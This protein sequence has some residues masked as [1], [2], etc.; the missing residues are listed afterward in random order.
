MPTYYR[1]I[2]PA[3]LWLN[4]LDKLIVQPHPFEATRDSDASS[5]TWSFWFDTLHNYNTVIGICAV[6]NF[7]PEYMG[8][9]R[10]VEN[11]IS[12]MAHNFYEINEVTTSQPQEIVE[13]LI[14]SAYKYA[15]E[16]KDFVVDKVLGRIWCPEFKR[17]K[18]QG[19]WLPLEGWDDE[20]ISTCEV[21]ISQDIEK[22]VKMTIVNFMDLPQFLHVAT[23]IKSL[24]YE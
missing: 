19:E 9:M 21:G 3:D 24:S 5:G 17:G 22:H 8:K 4:D 7:E 11:A 20:F 10:F 18:W 23:F 14:D 6:T 12:E 13:L 1:H 15:E 2:Q 16:A